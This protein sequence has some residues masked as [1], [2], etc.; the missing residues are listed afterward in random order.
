LNVFVHLR[1][2]RSGSRRF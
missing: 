2:H 1:T